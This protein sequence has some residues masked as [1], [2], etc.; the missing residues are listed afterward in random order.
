VD[1]D[2]LGCDIVLSNDWFMMFHRIVVSSSS[3]SYSPSFLYSED[4]GNEILSHAIL[5]SKNIPVDLCLYQC[6]P[7][8]FQENILLLSQ[9]TSSP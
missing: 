3:G 1:L 7:V 5:R 4:E 2:L 9:L 6:N 8:C